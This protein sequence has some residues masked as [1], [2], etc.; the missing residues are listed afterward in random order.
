MSPSPIPASPAL[1]AEAHAGPAR[2]GVAAWYGLFVLVLVSLVGALDK[3]IFP[4]VAEPIRLSLGL[5]D[6]QLG[7][8]Q[9]IGGILITSIAAFPLGWLSDRFD[10]RYVLAFSALVWSAASAWRGVAAGFPGLFVATLALSGGEAGLVPATYG[11]IPSLFPK[12]QRVFANGVYVVALYLAAYGGLALCGALLTG[13]EAARPHLPAALQ[14]VETWR[15]AFVILALPGPVVALLLLTLRKSNGTSEAAA[16]QAQ[17]PGAGQ[18]LL[19]YMRANWVA[20][21]GVCVGSGV[22]AIGSAVRLWSPVIAE[23]V[24]HATP[25]QAGGGLGAAGVVG[26]MVGFALTAGITR[27]F[28]ARLGSR[29]PPRVLW[30]GALASGVVSAA[31]LLAR[32]AT[33]FYVLVGVQAAIETAGSIVSPTL[34]QNLGPSHL[35]SRLI[36]LCVVIAMGINALMPI[37][38]GLISDAL[39]PDPA[40]LL[41]A[42]VIVGVAGTVLASLTFCLT[43]TPYKR[44]ADAVA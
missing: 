2:A 44:T 38:V 15:A 13:L 39:A 32:D 20:V 42:A 29:F 19:A 27:A 5:S 37:L 10:R 33:Q 35:R 25:G 3:Q 14:H 7:L 31:M 22:I 16:A 12:A 17:E 40:A 36:S 8:L 34:L 28:A 23:R 11:I 30:V 26:W 9:G 4:L 41:T 6:T 18:G 24:F 1:A 43:E 21:A